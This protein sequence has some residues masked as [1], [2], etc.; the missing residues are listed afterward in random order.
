MMGWFGYDFKSGGHTRMKYRILAFFLGFC[1]MHWTGTDL[2]RA[3]EKEK[4]PKTCGSFGTEVEFLASPNAAARLAN[5]EEKLLFVLH[6]SGNFET[7]EF[8]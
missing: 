3:E 1:V 6:V 4:S 2:S 5:K 7:P 8:T